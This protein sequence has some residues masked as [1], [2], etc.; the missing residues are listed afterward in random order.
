MGRLLLNPND[1]ALIAA[2]A[3]LGALQAF[4]AYEPRYDTLVE[5]GDR[6]LQ[7]Y[8]D[9]AAAA[10]GEVKLAYIVPDFANPTGET[11]PLDARRDLLTLAEAL[12]IAVIEDSAYHAL[13][14]EGAMLPSLQALDVARAGS[15]DA[16]RVVFLGTFSKTVAPGLRIGWICASRRLIR[17]LVLVKQ[18]SDLNVSVI[19]QMAMILSGVPP[20]KIYCLGCGPAGMMEIAIDAMLDIGVPAEHIVY[21]RF[22]YADGERQFSGSEMRNRKTIARQRNLRPRYAIAATCIRH[23]HS[24]VHIHHKRLT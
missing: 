5:Q 8:R 1:S 19:N 14:F 9:E 16:S 24:I 4:S 18:A 7:S 22:D 20:K 2:P 23:S 13:R 21:E 3:Y 6:S 12:D 11:T 17:R 15:L 10:G